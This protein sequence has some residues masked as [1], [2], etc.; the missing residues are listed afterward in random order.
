MDSHQSADLFA[1][2]TSHESVEPAAD[3]VHGVHKL[4]IEEEDDYEIHEDEYV[5]PEEIDPYD[6]DDSDAF[7][8]RVDIATQELQHAHKP[9]YTRALLERVK[10]WV[11]RIR[12]EFT[13]PSNQ[14]VL[15]HVDASGL[16]NKSYRV[17][18]RDDVN[19][20]TIQVE[21]L[22]R[23]EMH[24]D[25]QSRYGDHSEQ[26]RT[27]RRYN[28][29]HKQDCINTPYTFITFDRCFFNEHKNTAKMRTYWTTIQQTKRLWI[30]SAARRQ[31]V[32]AFQE[33]A[34]TCA[35]ITQ[36]V[37]FGIGAL[38]LK[39]NW[40]HSA[41]QYMAVFS[42]I[43]ALNQYYRQADP[44][45]PLIKLVLQDPNYETKDHEILRKLF[46]NNDNISFVSDP[47][48]LL[49]IDAGTLVVT[50]YLPFHMPLV[51]IIAD[52][53]SDNPGQGPAA[54]LCDIMEVD[55]EKREY[56]FSERT[57]P[58]VA[59]HFTNHY[60]RE[61]DRFEDHG[62]DDELMADAYGEDWL[63]KDRMY[64]LNKMDLWVRKRS[65]SQ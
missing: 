11:D 38:N 37:C 21:Y 10:D 57:S 26:I 24:P 15:D 30:A 1:T 51:Q 8:Y 44:A 54:I 18:N 64:W 29:D 22:S 39:K 27:L 2:T 14:R 13:L 42:I 36:V 12:G 35:P 53:I 5:T 19:A 34:K 4:A 60:E 16:N 63:E 31:L 17:W 45:R 6:P 47:D 23:V 41:I 20:N 55:T 49:A 28:K 9:V 32:E 3:V 25:F 58:H 61:E 33:T 48:G 56:S 7:E 65:A 40:Y 62:L 43:Q 59:R 46:N 52:L 50:A